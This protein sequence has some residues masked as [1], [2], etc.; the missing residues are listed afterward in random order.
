VQKLRISTIDLGAAGPVDLP[1]QSIGMLAASWGGSGNWAAI[2]KDI[3]YLAERVFE[4]EHAHGPHGPEVRRQWHHL[5]LAVGNFKRQ[6]GMIEPATVASDE[7]SKRPSRPS[8]LRLPGTCARLDRDDPSTW[9]SLT[10]IPGLG[11]PT[12]T[13]LLSALWPGHHTIID[14]RDI[15]A[16]VGLGRRSGWIGQAL[17]K[18]WLPETLD[19]E[20]YEWLR[21]SIDATPGYTMV[22]VERA[23]YQLDRLTR[24]AL[25]MS[26]KWSEYRS[27]ALDQVPG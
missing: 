6:A 13:T 21:S 25:G 2:W 12:A 20:W 24:P 27:A 10:A 8:E 1:A 16:A 18:A 15:T 3:E 26:W 7:P 5:L 23:L 17:D 4:V 9:P 19:W 14:R 11:V 22:Q